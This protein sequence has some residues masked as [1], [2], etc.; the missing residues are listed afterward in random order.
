MII[1]NKE[2]TIFTATKTAIG[3]KPN[4]TTTIATTPTMMTLVGVTAVS[5]QQRKQRKRQ[6]LYFNFA[7][8][9]WGRQLGNTPQA[10]IG[11]ATIPY[12]YFS[13]RRNQCTTK[14]FCKIGIQEVECYTH[15]VSINK[16]NWIERQKK[17]ALAT[18]LL[19]E[20]N[21]NINHIQAIQELASTVLE[22]APRILFLPPASTAVS[23]PTPTEFSSMTQRPMYNLLSQLCIG[24]PKTDNEM[25][26]LL[27]K[28][29]Y[30]TIIFL[31][32]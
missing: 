27:M 26:A 20:S 17:P 11:D 23:I 7:K 24:I 21:H 2:P 22:V 18:F 8:G 12:Y 4:S 6:A 1:K 3:T 32:Q 9:V 13:F 30:P 25:K 29:Y 10:N 15:K 31:M 28:N 19:Q 16:K 14:I 5:Q